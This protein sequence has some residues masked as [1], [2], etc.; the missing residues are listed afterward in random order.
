MQAPQLSHLNLSHK[1][2]T[3]SATFHSLFPRR[4]NKRICIHLIILSF[5]WLAKHPSLEART[6]SRVS[7]VGHFSED[8][9]SVFIPAVITPPD[10][11]K[12]QVD[13]NLLTCMFH[14]VIR[15]TGCEILQ[16]QESLPIQTDMRLMVR[17]CI[18]SSGL[19]SR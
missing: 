1:H 10:A 12:T 18:H 16:D 17:T 11:A 4:V 19:C 7:L 13:E 8:P 14:Q 2:I 15:G 6:H 9:E 3:A 5:S